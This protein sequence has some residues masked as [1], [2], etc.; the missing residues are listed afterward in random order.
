MSLLDDY[1]DMTAR[2]AR[3]EERRDA[4]SQPATITFEEL[5]DDPAHYVEITDP[6]D[7]GDVVFRLLVRMKELDSQP[8]GDAAFGAF[9]RQ[10]LT[11]ELRA[12]VTRNKR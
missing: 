12:A 1:T 9:A 3:Y 10:T 6:V 2:E 7:L 11:E 4:E 5:F 8:W